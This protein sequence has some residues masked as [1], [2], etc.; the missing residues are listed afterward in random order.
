MSEEDHKYYVDV[1]NTPNS[2]HKWELRLYRAER[3]K[4]RYGPYSMGYLWLTLPWPR[5]VINYLA[6]RMIKKQI[7][8]D[9]REA[10]GSRKWR[11]E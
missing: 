3:E 5:T 7:R 10:N 4:S 1:V 11:V 9:V 2:Y 8:K 6:K